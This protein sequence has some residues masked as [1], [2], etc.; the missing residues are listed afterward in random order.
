MRRILL[1][2]YEYLCGVETVIFRQM[3]INVRYAEEKLKKE[4]LHL[5]TGVIIARFLLL[6]RKVKGMRINVLFVVAN[7][8]I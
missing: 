4:F 1:K 7:C 8:D 5:P 6:K 3:R 2:E